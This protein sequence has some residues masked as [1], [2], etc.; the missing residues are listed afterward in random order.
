MRSTSAL[1][2][3]RLKIDDRE[4]RVRLLA[5]LPTILKPPPEHLEDIKEL[6]TCITAVLLK[7]PSPD[8]EIR[9]RLFSSDVNSYAVRDVFVDISCNRYQFYQITGETPETLINPQ[10]N[11]NLEGLRPHKLSMRN[12]VLLC[13]MWLR[14]YPTYNLL[15][16]MFGVAVATIENEIKTL[17]PIFHEKL[18]SFIK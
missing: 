5:I 4:R 6:I 15:A 13:V 11:V 9:F 14:S 18:H 1:K 3:K 12:R 2:H 7:P 10:H 16:V 17:I 8:T